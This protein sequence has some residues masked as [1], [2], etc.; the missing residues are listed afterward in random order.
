MFAI[1]SGEYNHCICGDKVTEMEIPDKECVAKDQR[2]SVL[3]Q[4]TQ[5]PKNEN[6]CPESTLCKSVTENA[7][8]CITGTF[9]VKI[10]INIFYELAITT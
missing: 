10:L 1:T 9:T 4:I 5:C 2:Y 7:G 8:F 6:E 3:F